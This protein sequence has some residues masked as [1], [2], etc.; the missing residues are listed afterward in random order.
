[1]LN[2]RLGIVHGDNHFGNVLI[3]PEKKVREYQI[4]K[5]TL[6]RESN[7]RV[8]LYDF[9]L[10]FMFDYKNKELDTPFNQQ[11]GRTNI[12]NYAKDIWTLI[13][14]IGYLLKYDTTKVTPAWKSWYDNM[15]NNFF[16]KKINNEPFVQTYMFD[17]VN[18]VLLQTKEQR[19]TLLENFQAH[20]NTNSYWNLFCKIPIGTSCVPPNFPELHPELLL[21]RYI[22]F[23]KSQLN[24]TDANAYYKKYYMTNNL[25]KYSNKYLKYKKKYLKLKAQLNL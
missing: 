22:E 16:G 12:Q 4:D 9:D 1:M 2:V 14:N 25:R 3:K 17:L 7:Y 19:D 6:V 24:F 15:Q 5:T 11:I 21:K 8:C 20:I 23:Y 10:S 13:N 18:N